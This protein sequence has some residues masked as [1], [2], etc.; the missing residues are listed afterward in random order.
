MTIKEIE[1]ILK[2]THP[3]K[4]PDA[5]ALYQNDTRSAVASLI[6]KYQKVHD[7]Y[8]ADLCSPS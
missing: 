1:N 5:L 3:E 6:V 7:N 4:L 2:N 8:L